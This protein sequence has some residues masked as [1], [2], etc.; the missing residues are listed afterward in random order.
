MRKIDVRQELQNILEKQF[1]QDKEKEW[2]SVEKININRV[3]ITIVSEKDESI[4]EIQKR[5]ES[6]IE[7]FNINLENYEKIHLGFLNVYTVEEA[8]F[9]GI[10]KLRKEKQ[11]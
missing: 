7:E 2:I 3:D 10:E 6:L 1:V 11:P 9:I 5:I 8:E 4:N